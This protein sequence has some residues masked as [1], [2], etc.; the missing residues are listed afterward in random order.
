MGVS[1]VSTRSA[2]SRAQIRAQIPA[3]DLRFPGRPKCATAHTS[4]GWS[5]RH[6]RPAHRGAGQAPRVKVERPTG[7]TTLAR[8]AWSARLALGRWRRDEQ[9]ST[10]ATRQPRPGGRRPSWSP[11]SPPEAMNKSK[12]FSGPV[13]CHSGHSRGRG[14]LDDRDRVLPSLCRGRLRRSGRR[15]SRRAQTGTAGQRCRRT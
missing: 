1:L 11:R 14:S 4:S 6:R 3:A 5:S 7:R 10:P 9:A 15:W 2:E 13:T 12:R 8:G